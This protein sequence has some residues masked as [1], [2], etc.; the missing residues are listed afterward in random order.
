[1]KDQDIEIHGRS[2]FLQGILLADNLPDTLK[3]LNVKW[4]LYQEKLKKHDLVPLT[5]IMSWIK[6]LDKID[7]WVIGVNS[8]LELFEI[9]NAYANAEKYFAFDFALLNDPQ[10]PYINPINWVKK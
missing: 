2:L 9:F 8:E 5:A 1:M 7:K 4:N 6:T 10:N 3:P